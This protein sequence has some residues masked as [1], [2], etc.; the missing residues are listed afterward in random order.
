MST[1]EHFVEQF[2]KLLERYTH[3]LDS[4]PKT[5]GASAP[6]SSSDDDHRLVAT[7]RLAILELET[8]TRMERNARKFFAEP[9]KAEWGC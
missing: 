4:D 7:A 8:A 1:Q 2:A 5:E 6:H 3:A 9:G